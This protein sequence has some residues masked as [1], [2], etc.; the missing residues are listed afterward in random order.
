MGQALKRLTI[1]LSDLQVAI[2]LLLLIALTGATGSNALAPQRS[3]DLL[4]RNG[5]T[6]LSITIEDFAIERDPAGRP[7]QFRSQL[8]LSTSREP[9]LKESSVNHP[10]RHRGMTIYQADWSLATITVQ[11]G[12][13]PELELPLQSFP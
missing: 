12:R 9:L 1:W 7:E 2:V 11:I 3:L 4:D 8:A 5:N 6:Q 10:L 13:S